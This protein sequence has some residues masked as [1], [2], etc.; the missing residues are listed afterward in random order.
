MD[1]TA[2]WSLLLVAAWSFACISVPLPSAGPKLEKITLPA[3][4]DAA[5]S[6][7]QAFGEPQRL[8]ISAAWVYEWTTD[9]KFVVV[10][11]MPTGM[12]VGAAV[13][14]NRY[15]MLV[16]FDAEGRVQRISCTSREA[17]ADDDPVLEC[18]TQLGPL[19]ERARPLFSYRLDDNLA[20]EKAS[21]NQSGGTG[22][23]T[24]MIL[25][26]D[27]RLLATTDSKNRL[28]I[29]DAE[30]GEVIHRHD[31]EPIKF[32]SLAPVGQVKAVFADN[33]RQL[34]IAQYKVGI[35]VLERADDG[36]FKTTVSMPDPDIG[37]VT[38]AGDD[39]TIF[40]FGEHG[41]SILQPD[42]LRKAA[43]DPAA[44]LDFQVNGPERVEPPAAAADLTGVRFGQSWWTGGRSAVFTA[45]GG[46][47]ALL[48][49]RND[50]ARVGKQGYGFSSDGRMLA[51][52]TGRHIEMWRSAD[53]FGVVD[54]RL[55]AAEVAPS[56]VALMPFTNRRDEDPTGHLPI[57]F[58]EG[59]GLVATAS[60]AAIHV[61]RAEGGE[62][63]ALIGAMR[64]Q[65]HHPSGESTIARRGTF[66]PAVGRISSRSTGSTANRKWGPS[67]R[68]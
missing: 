53:I 3:P 44:R 24:P 63:V 45:D 47:V 65:Y 21:F 41:I 7:R 8:D 1:R 56:W 27:G 22:A 40:A 36:T 13:A 55:P 12:P 38:V 18:E 58:R 28:W 26:A 49:L 10:P 39:R 37:Q 31:G 67:P 15:R 64:S 4:G 14:G 23:S 5:S 2:R 46:G 57:A 52:N 51:H 20:F 6:V 29:L 66:R 30:T 42:G 17:P 16:A 11:V 60:R 34:V 59:G 35:E 32:F 48:D 19:R 62:P 25:S 54:G 33:G 68:A 61:W 43:I 50:T 9:R